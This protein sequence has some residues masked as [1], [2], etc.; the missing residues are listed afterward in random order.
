VH[1]FIERDEHVALDV[2]T[3]ART[4]FAGCF[5]HKLIVEAVAGSTTE[6]LLE[7]VTEAGAAK[8]EL[9]IGTGTGMRRGLLLPVCAEAIVFLSF[10]VSGWYWRASLR[11]AFLMSSALASRGTPRMA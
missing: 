8:M 1:G 7:E 4:A 6:I 5:R 3:A 2:V 9:L 11:K 10:A